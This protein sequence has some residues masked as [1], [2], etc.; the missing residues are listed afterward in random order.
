MLSV[1]CGA[2][3]FEH[4]EVT[5]HDPVFKRVFGFERMTNFKAILRLFAKFTQGVNESVMDSLYRWMRSLNFAQST[6]T[7]SRSIWTRP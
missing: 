7:A 4:T 1:W 3:R 2:N 5:R 6:S